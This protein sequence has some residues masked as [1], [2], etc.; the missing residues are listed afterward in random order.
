MSEE[1][2]AQN[3]QTLKVSLPESLEPTYANIFLVVDNGSE[4]IIDCAQALPNMPMVKIKAR[5]VVTA[6]N[7]KRLYGAL[8]KHIDTFEEKYGEIKLPDDL[9]TQL[10]SKPTGKESSIDDVP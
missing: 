2:K 4:F 9:S 10:F 7:A 1:K 8:G 3:T 6:I 5:I